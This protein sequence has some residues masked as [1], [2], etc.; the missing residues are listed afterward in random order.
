[1]T[2]LIEKEVTEKILDLIT[3][4]D[5]KNA[6][7]LEIDIQKDGGLTYWRI[8]VKFELV[9]KSPTYKINAV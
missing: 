6:E 3:P 9:D 7:I 1:M 2:P 4:K 5:I 8:T